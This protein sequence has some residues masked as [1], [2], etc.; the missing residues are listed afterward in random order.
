MGWRGITIGVVVAALASGA[1]KLSSGGGGD[2]S[3]ERLELAGQVMR[4]DLPISV[5]ERGNLKA[6][7]S[8]ELKSEIEG[9]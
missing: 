1:W 9:S 7:N 8:I 2:G 3:E 5:V 4:G 6:A